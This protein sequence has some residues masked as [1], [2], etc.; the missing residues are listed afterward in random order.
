MKLSKEQKKYMPLVIPLSKPLEDLTP[1][2]AK[3]YFE[4]YVSHVDERAEYVRQKVI[5]K[6][7]IRDEA[8]DYSMESMIPLW[9]WFLG[10]LGFL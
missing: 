6:L 1:Q 9:K 5:R 3:A 4:W 8:M 7:K 10:I 2:E